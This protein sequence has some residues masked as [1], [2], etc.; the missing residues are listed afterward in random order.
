MSCRAVDRYR[1]A[2]GNPDDR[3]VDAR[4]ADQAGAQSARPVARR[5]RVDPAPQLRRDRQVAAEPRARARRGGAPRRAAARAQHDAAR[6]RV[7]S[8]LLVARPVRP[9]DGPGQGV[10]AAD[11]RRAR[12]V[13]GRRDR[14]A[15]E[16]RAGQ[17][18]GGRA[19]RWICPSRSCRLRRTCSASACIPTG[20][21]RAPSTS[22]SGPGTSCASCA[23]RSC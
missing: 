21:R 12:S 1:C 17:R 15:V 10:A 18:R 6:R 4:L 5:R 3:P 8:P 19:H 2:R 7:R 14:P 23:A 11:A 20:S 13:P 22:T 16:H 9:G